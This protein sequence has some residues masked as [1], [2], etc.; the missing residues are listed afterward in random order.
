VN[1][2]NNAQVKHLKNKL[3]Q[4]RSLLSSMINASSTTDADFTALAG[5]VHDRADESVAD[6]L[7]DIQIESR[8]RAISKLTA[9]DEALLSIKDKSYG[10]CIDCGDE[11]TYSRLEAY[12]V[13]KRCIRCKEVFERNNGSLAHAPSL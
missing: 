3:Q 9:I 1:G 7:G 4:Q 5:E 10:R 13:A 11:I 8:Y 12:S 6:L 2:L